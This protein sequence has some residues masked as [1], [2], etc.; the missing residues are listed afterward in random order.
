MEDPLIGRESRGGGTDRIVRRSEAITHG[1][2]F[3]KAAGL[4]DLA[5]DGIG[6]PEQ[7]LDQSSFAKY[8]FIF[9]RLDL[10]WSL[11][12]FALILINFFEQPLWC[13]K[14]HTPS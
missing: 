10:I 2:L 6:L 13:E 1:T 14:Q 5:E 8:Y 9:T 3:Q 7:I 12:Y 4:V 11:N